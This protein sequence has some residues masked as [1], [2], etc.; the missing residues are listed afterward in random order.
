MA[1][2]D[3]K[4]T[5]L[6][7]RTLPDEAI[8][9]ARARADV[10]VHT[11]DAPLTR[12][13]L[14]DRL[15][16]RRGLVCLITDTID[17]EVLAVPGLRVVS[18]VAVGYNNIDVAA[19]TR[20]GIAIT[21]TPDVLNETTADFTWALLMA[22]ARRVVEADRYVRSGRFTQW[23]YMA[24]LGGDVHGKTLGVI[25]LGRIGR[26]VARRA[27]GFG[28][29]V[30]YCDATPAPPAV[31]QELSARRVDLATLL[32]DA[33]F[34]TVHTPLVPETRHLIGADALRAMK[35][36]AY[37]VNA[38][39]GPVV[40]EAALARALREGWIAGAGLDVYEDEPAVHPDLFGLDNVVLSPHIASASHETR[41][42]MAALAVENCV[43]VLE[44][45]RPPCPVNPEVLAAR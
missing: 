7:S 41:V 12:A 42:K 32:R 18:N 14:I 40:D 15:R 22:A 24:L 21:N 17:A 38:S 3:D 8:D 4:P 11:G 29:R 39:R 25:G 2:D 43:A 16:G 26:A 33:D 35:K 27:Q 34:V 9:L 28:M 31:E 5:I 10:A 23:E 19:A 36:T 30:L 13:A 37:L 20:R 6:I 44:G 45:R 1:A